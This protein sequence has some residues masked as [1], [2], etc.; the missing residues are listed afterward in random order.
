MKYL[1]TLVLLVFSAVA[2]RA[3]VLDPMLSSLMSK[4][5]KAESRVRRMKAQGVE[6]REVKPSI[7]TTLIKQSMEVSFNEN[8]T[9]R[10]VVVIA[11]LAEGAGLPTDELESLGVKVTMHS[12]SFAILNVPGEAMERLAQMK[13]FS[14]LYASEIQK[15][16][17]DRT[18]E[19]TS[20][21][22]VTGEKE[23]TQIPTKY[24]GEG[25][26]V[27]IIDQ[28]I[29][30]NHAA[31]M[32]PATGET[33]IKEAVYFDK[34]GMH[35]ADDEASIAAL[36]TMC[37]KSSH[38]T[39]TSA[40]AAGSNVSG[41]QG[42]APGAEL[43]LCDLGD[44]LPVSS[45]ISSVGEIF[46]YADS[47][48]KPAVINMSFGSNRYFHDG[49]HPVPEFVKQCVGEGKIVCV[50]AGNSGRDKLS[51]VKTLG[52]ADA[53]GYQLKTIFNGRYSSEYDVT[54][55]SEGLKA[56]IYADDT[57]DIDVELKVID[58][59]TGDLYSFDVIPL[60]YSDTGKIVD[61]N[62][63]VTKGSKTYCE[64]NTKSVYFDGSDFHVALLV[65]GKEGQKI[66]I[67]TDGSDLCG[68]ETYPKL[69]GYVEGN[70]DLSIN[71]DA[72][73]DAMI[74]V[75]SYVHR[76]AFNS[77]DG[78][79]YGVDSDKQVGRIATY[80]SYG[81]D[82]NGV[83]RP[84]FLTPGMWMVSA[85]SL[86]DTT[87]FTNQSLD[88][89]TAN[90]IHITNWFTPDELGANYA[91]PSA[92]GVMQGT[93]MSCPVA[94]GIVALWLQANPHLTPADVRRIARVACLND[95]WTN[96]VNNIPSGN[97]VQAGMGKLDALR[98]IKYIENQKAGEEICQLD[99]TITFQNG[100]ATY[101]SDKALDFRSSTVPKAYIANSYEDN[102]LNL[103]RMGIVPAGTG[104]L[105]LD[106]EGGNGTYNVPIAP[107]ASTIETNYFVGTADSPV[108][109]A[110]EGEGYVLSKHNDVLGFYQ[111]A[112]NLTVP[113]NK[114]YLVL[115]DDAGNAANEVKAF[116]FAFKES[117]GDKAVTDDDYIE[118]TEEDLP[119]H[120]FEIIHDMVD[121][122]APVQVEAE[123]SSV[124][125]N[126]L[127]QRVSNSFRGIIIKNGKKYITK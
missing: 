38:G 50:S 28:G 39:H 103:T 104:L 96:D 40:T 18:R 36:T 14:N 66:T 42:M 6:P 75:G 55:Y 114:A 54:Y 17:N 79:P 125:Y 24:T 47:V 115:P 101:S 76:R 9:V 10:S 126:I 83:A 89:N 7:D 65:K 123:S 31:F 92:Y 48:G 20:V 72:C 63:E 43:V 124:T 87:T 49:S 112:A 102:V 51:V 3:Q 90:Y 120:R 57:Q 122:I 44:I 59:T 69:E 60:Y 84:D 37:T 118:L 71:T 64:I 98:G 116:A 121:G 25:V 30:F 8:G 15:L 33:R 127:G 62:V 61:V 29:D 105:L 113:Q 110:R 27:G 41:Y 53:D 100:I 108:T 23:C 77:I 88:E 82:E 2:S 73:D 111:N 5:A 119:L 56:I 93:S 22:Y 46:R 74:S 11:K 109:L 67:I 1:L 117:N 81:V 21:S 106:N 16:C 26:V 107:S 97:I 45:I 85:Y 58:V 19:Y 94:T 68:A 80:S 70:A 95:K 13:A 12:G 99:E 34:E 32:D 35:V 86:Y 78:Y 52:S 91:R 4:N